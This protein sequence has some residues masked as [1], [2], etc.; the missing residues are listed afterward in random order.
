MAL[1]TYGMVVKEGL[2]DTALYQFT[3][4]LV[5]TVHQMLGDLE[6]SMRF[7]ELHARTLESRDRIAGKLMPTLK[8][9]WATEYF[10]TGS[11]L[12]EVRKKSKGG[13]ES[14]SL[15]SSLEC[16]LNPPGAGLNLFR[17]IRHHLSNAYTDAEL[18]IK[19]P[20]EFANIQGGIVQLL[21]NKDVLRNLMAEA[22][23]PSLP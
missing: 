8:E 3:V 18:E 7:A 9:L 11:L 20:E 2:Q 15:L 5:I 23:P 22:I 6:N 1:E 12:W 19:S 21:E 4:E 17:L 14:R 16:F 10:H 13:M